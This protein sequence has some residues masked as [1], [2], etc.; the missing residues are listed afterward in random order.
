MNATLAPWPIDGVSITFQTQGSRLSYKQSTKKILRHMQMSSKQTAA[1][2]ESN[3]VMLAWS[4]LALWI[5]VNQK[6]NWLCLTWM[7]AS[8]GQSRP[9]NISMVPHQLMGMTISKKLWTQLSMILVT[10]AVPKVVMAENTLASWLPVPIEMWLRVTSP[11]QLMVL[12]VLNPTL[13]QSATNFLIQTLHAP[14][15]HLP[16][17][18]A[19]SIQKTKSQIMHAVNQL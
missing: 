7:S 17:L 4:R 16:S 19:V 18:R 15:F 9:S 1:Q 6:P 3:S 8:W 14:Q 5:W 12:T 10:N 13:I 11:I 2:L